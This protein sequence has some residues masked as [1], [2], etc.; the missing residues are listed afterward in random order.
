MILV[1]MPLARQPAVSLTDC[2]PDHLASV[3]S[4][5][6]INHTYR[7]VSNALTYTQSSVQRF[8]IGLVIA[9][10][11]RC[12]FFGSQCRQSEERYGSLTRPESI[13]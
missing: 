3:I 6:C 1:L 2:D 5:A 12:S 10:I 4:L 11:Q 7:T 9:K 13:L 8:D